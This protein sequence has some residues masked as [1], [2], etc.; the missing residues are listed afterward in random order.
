MDEEGE[1]SGHDSDD[2]V[3]DSPHL[4]QLHDYFT[5]FIETHSIPCLSFGEMNKTKFRKTLPKL[6]L[7]PTESSG[8][9]TAAFSFFPFL[10][11]LLLLHS[12][13]CLSVSLSHSLPPSPSPPHLCLSLS[14]SLFLLLPHPVHCPKAML[15]FKMK[16]F[17]VVF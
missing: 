16:G 5:H 3:S 7:V 1:D 14:L 13:L 10:L 4:H 8:M 15:A 17:P 12:L 9:S 11:L 6:L 2:G